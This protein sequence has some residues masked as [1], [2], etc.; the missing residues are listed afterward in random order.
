MKLLKIM[1]SKVRGGME[2]GDARSQ[3]LRA[4]RR[5]KK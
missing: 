1:L 4:K 5:R 2:E 3:T